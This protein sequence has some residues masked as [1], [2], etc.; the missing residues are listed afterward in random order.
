MHVLPQVAIEFRLLHLRVQHGW[1]LEVA[2]N[3]LQRATS[4][5]L[6]C[7][8]QVFLLEWLGG[9]LTRVSD[10]ERLSVRIIVGFARINRLSLDI[11]DFNV[12]CLELVACRCELRITL[13]LLV[14]RRSPSVS[15]E[16][17]SRP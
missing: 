16:L 4:P 14:D 12:M 3:L 2:L 1:W 6:L 11:L 7:S 10:I 5:A 9:G 13:L 15:V 17:M 8:D